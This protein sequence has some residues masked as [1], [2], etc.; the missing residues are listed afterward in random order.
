MDVL[1]LPRI[2]FKYF[3]NSAGQAGTL[4]GIVLSLGIPFSRFVYRLAEE[5]KRL[6]KP[7]FLFE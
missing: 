2:V 6:Q 1:V 3:K 7:A 5:K 4:L